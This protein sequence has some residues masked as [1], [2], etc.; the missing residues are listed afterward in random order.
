MLLDLISDPISGFDP[1]LRQKARD[2]AR[3]HI[4]PNAEAWEAARSYPRDVVRLASQEFGGFL[5][6]KEHGG[7]GYAPTDFLMM[8]EEFAKADIGFTLAFVV[9]HHVGLVTSLSGNAALRDRLLPDLISGDKIGAFCLTE[10]RA[11]SDAAGVETRAS[12]DVDGL[13]LSGRKSW[14]TSGAVADVL[15][16]FAKTDQEAGARG[17]GCFAV[18]GVAR[19]VTR[20]A[21]Y[22]L[23]AGHVAQVCDIS[24]DKV[25]LGEA[26]TLFPAGQ[27]FAT[28]MGALDVARLGIAAMCTGAMTSALETA[29]AHASNRRMFGATTLDQQGIQWAFAEHLTELEASRSL[30]FQTARLFE[31]EKPA[32]LAAAHTKKYANRAANEGLGWA[33]RAMGAEGSRRRNPLARQH[34]AAQL[35]FNT[36]GTPE[37]MNVVIG[38]SL[39]QAF[40]T[41]ED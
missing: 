41:K 2:F 7:K 1:E 6:A 15:A 3:T 22:D 34:G 33:M 35:L 20:G 38:R 40:P 26:D 28:A 30:M 17:I 31:A 13:S 12:G 18:D 4:A 5:V 16:V 27:G 25:A 19:G 9:H 36:D 29:L 32:T 23:I 11:G 21:C 39:A 24:F 14:V 10:P 8:V 37:I